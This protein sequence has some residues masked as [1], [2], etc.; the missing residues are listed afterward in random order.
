MA[1]PIEARQFWRNKED[2][3]EVITRSDET[4]EGVYFRY[5]DDHNR[6]NVS[7]LPVDKFR[8]QFERLYFPDDLD[9]A[10]RGF[11]EQGDPEFVRHAA[12]FDHIAEE[13]E[14]KLKELRALALRRLRNN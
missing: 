6:N 1:S 3:R 11:A 5:A 10:W 12:R 14:A 2:G 7:N 8:A 4:D 13:Y 9:A